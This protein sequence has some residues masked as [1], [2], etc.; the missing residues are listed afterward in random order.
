[1][2]AAA[3]PQP[4]GMRVG[5]WLA[6][7]AWLGVGGWII[8]RSY[9]PVL[10]ERDPVLAHALAPG[11]GRL[12]ASLAYQRLERNPSPAGQAEAEGL[13]RA[14][15]ERDPTRVSAV[16]ALG[17]IAQ[18][19]GDIGRARRWFGYAEKLTRRDLPTELW[20]I[21]N[22]V[23]RADVA[24]ALRHYD[25]A[26]RTNYGAGDLLFPVLAKASS[27]PQIA[28]ALVPVLAAKPAWSND[29]LNFLAT[30]R[31]NPIASSQLFVMLD[32]AGG[33]IEPAITNRLIALMLTKDPEAAWSFYAAL[34]RGADRTRLRDPSFSGAA[35]PP[36]P[37]DWTVLDAEGLFG[38]IQRSGEFG[39]FAFNASATVG[40]E[41]LQQTMLLPV[42]RYRLEGRTRDLTQSGSEAPYWSLKCLADGRE[43]ARV[44]MSQ[45]ADKA[46]RFVGG[47]TVP[48]DCRV[49]RLVLVVQPS[50]AVEGASGTV[51]HV[52]LRRTF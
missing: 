18:L 31:D 28:R 32:H 4:M 24:A 51:E 2:T 6:A 13:A 3:A 20:L 46:G 35:N 27:D 30:S 22:A 12:S 49:Q 38:S 19:Q 25:I 15:L 37:F 21:E 34:H 44:P 45:G 9:A 17:L 41:L 36:S 29:F 16:A 42:G 26:L 40:G 10:A 52:E 33:A 7:L 5:R 8:V 47:L 23:Q 48:A 14:A 50:A 39:V 11:D 43:L 1:M